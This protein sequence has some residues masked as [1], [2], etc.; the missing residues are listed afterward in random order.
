MAKGLDKTRRKQPTCF[1]C[2]VTADDAHATPCR[3]HTGSINDNSELISSSIIALGIAG[4]VD[5]DMVRQIQSQ[6]FL[7]SCC[8]TWMNDDRVV[9]DSEYSEGCSQ[10]KS[11][12]F[13]VRVLCLVES[14][15]RPLAEETAHSLAEMGD[16]E[17]LIA[18]IATFDGHVESDI[19]AVALITG[20]AT[21]ER[22]MAIADG[23]RKGCPDIALTIFSD[24]NDLNGWRLQA[25]GADGLDAEAMR[26]SL[27]QGLQH[28][29]GISQLPSK[30]FFLSYTRA[31]IDIARE[32]AADIV[33]GAGQCWADWEMLAPGVEW[34]AE[35]ENGI[36]GCR[37]FLLVLTEQT[38]D[39]TYCWRELRLA[40]EAGAEIT[41]VA[42]GII[43]AEKLVNASVPGFAAWRPAYVRTEAEQQNL[44]LIEDTAS[45]QAVC[46]IIPK[47]IEDES[48]LGEYLSRKKII[49]LIEEGACASALDH[50]ATEVLLQDA[51][52]RKAELTI[53]RTYFDRLPKDERK[54]IRK[55]NQ[56]KYYEEICE[57]MGWRAEID[58]RLRNHYLC[59]DDQEYWDDQ[60]ET[61]Q[62][63]LAD[64]RQRYGMHEERK[65][66]F[67]DGWL[68]FFR[69]R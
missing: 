61:R 67:K 26:T 1:L 50:E 59:I 45:K 27:I 41:I 56:T 14:N 24:P 4:N 15:A 20:N 3:Y 40:R 25:S 63:I 38:P 39:Q 34:S 52:W 18:D 32:W 31:N 49:D 5:P 2:G 46:I 13:S 7:Y 55:E 29:A 43:A 6:R 33:K 60:V 64:V 57:R 12:I 37:A 9:A 22:S 36:G 65:I 28:R 51:D 8:S 11:H 23:I 68:R 35:I 16:F 47:A 48:W 42:D 53:R 62:E 66:R 58:M 69:R 17:L 19:A 21:K 44:S 10:A 54:A 30:P